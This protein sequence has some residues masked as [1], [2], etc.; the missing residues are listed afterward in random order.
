VGDDLLEG[1]AVLGIPGQRVE[2][3]GVDAGGLDLVDVVEHRDGVPVLRGP[4]AV[5]VLALPELGQARL[6]VAVLDVPGGLELVEGAQDLEVGVLRELRHVVGE[7]VRGGVGDHAGGE[8]VPVL[9]PSDLGDVD[10][11]AGVLLSEVVGALLVAGLLTGVPQPVLDGAAGAV[12]RG[13]AAGRDR[14]HYGDERCGG[15]GG[16]GQDGHCCLT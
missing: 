11:Q 2:G 1:A 8:L 4:V 3:G 5:S 15:A 12:G 16:S 10:R 7:D 14:G 13:G 6:V 9:G